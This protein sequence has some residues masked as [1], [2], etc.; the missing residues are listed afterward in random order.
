MIVGRVTKVHG[1]TCEA[2]FTRDVREGDFVHYKIDDQ[3]VLCQIYIMRASPTN[4]FY[5]RLRILDASAKVPNIW[6]NL[7]LTHQKISGYIDIG[8]TFRNQPFKLGINPFFYHTLVPGI[9]GSGKTHLQIVLQEEFINRRVPSIVIDTQGEFIHLKGAKVVEDVRIED[10]LGYLKTRTCLVYNLQGLPNTT[11]AQRC[12]EILSEIKD[13]KVKDYKRAENDIKLL[14]LPPVLIDVDE[15]EIYAPTRNKACLSRP[16]REVIIDIAKRG[17]KL[18]IG[19][20]VCSQRLPALHYDVRSQCNSAM[21]FQL[22][23]PGS[24]TVLSQLA[25]ISNHELKLVN[26]LQIGQCLV[27]GAH[28]RHPTTVL[29][30]DI[31][32]Q[33]S[34]CLDFEKMLG[35]TKLSIPISESAEKSPFPEPTEEQPILPFD[36]VKKNLKRQFRPPII[37]FNQLKEQFPTRTVPP[38][39]ECIVIPERNFDQRWRFPLEQEGCIEVF[40]AGDNAS[41]LIRKKNHN[42]LK[43]IKEMASTHLPRDTSKHAY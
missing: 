33:R 39:G 32:T 6:D 27:T 8:K 42:E 13:A 21:V 36:Q 41:F 17:G 37:S 23:D 38:H 3:E 11:K 9:T 28:I 2:E 5:G 31:D 30:R 10:V 24:R 34:K 15:T 18:G 22:N 26:N 29:V 4:G 43:K 20:I 19:L 40:V 14:E 12:F 7:F 25:Y 35:L 1:S 16:C